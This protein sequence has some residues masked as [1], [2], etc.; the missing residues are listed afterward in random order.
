MLYEGRE[1]DPESLVALLDTELK[2]AKPS[3][4]LLEKLGMNPKTRLGVQRLI[5]EVE[6]DRIIPELDAAQPVLDEMKAL[7]EQ[8]AERDKKEQEREAKRADDEEKRETAR[9]LE[10][11]RALLRGKGYQKEGIEKIEAIMVERNIPD[12]DAAMALWERDQPKDNPAIPSSLNRSWDFLMPG[13]DDKDTIAAVS[14]P[15]GRGQENALQRATM[16]E[17]AATLK[18][19]RTGRAA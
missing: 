7:R 19:L 11:G 18:D 6:P 4:A 9:R 3:H 2:K 5:K 16:K 15:K 1:F 17:V 12:Y 14:L 10:S 8:L 13:E